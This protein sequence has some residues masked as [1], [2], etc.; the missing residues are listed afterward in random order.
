MVRL[1]A[2]NDLCPKP[3]YVDPVVTHLQS[4]EKD[5]SLVFSASG[6]GVELQ[7]LYSFRRSCLAGKYRSHECKG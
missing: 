1:I 5:P 4:H 6:K 7:W 3:C 2:L